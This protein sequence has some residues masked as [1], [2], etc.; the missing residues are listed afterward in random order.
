MSIIAAILLFIF[1]VFYIYKVYKKHGISFL[2]NPYSICIVL[3]ST[4]LCLYDFKFSSLYNPSLIINGLVLFIITVFLILYRFNHIEET[5]FIKLTENLKTTKIYNR[6]NL[7]SDVIFIAASIVF[8]YNISKY[9]LAILGSNKIN[10]QE[11]THYS[12]YFINL[13]VI[14]AQIKY[15]NFRK[16]KRCHD[17]I[18]L[19][20]SVMI[21]FLTLNRMPI[22]FIFATIYIYEIINYLKIK[23]K[24]DRTKRNK[25]IL[26][27]VIAIIVFVLA[28]GYVGNMRMDYVLKNIYHTTLQEHYGMSSYVPVSLVWVYIYLTSPLE[29][30]SFSLV[31]QHIQYT[32]FNNLF[33]PF[34]KFFANIFNQG[35]NYKAWVMSRV[36]YT[37]HL[38]E[39]VGLNVS[40]FITEGGFQDLGFIGFVIYIAIYSV[41][42]E[43]IIKLIKQ[44]R[45]ISSL[46]VYII[47]SN[48]LNL[49]IMS[50]YVNSLGIS[51]LIINII[52]V[53]VIELDYRKNYSSNL[54]NFVTKKVNSWKKR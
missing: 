27:T 18:I 48:I 6:Y 5:E 34:I 35:D 19:I 52:L 44:K 11:L 49:L 29:N 13:L 1:V 2:L 14:C 16:L 53:L 3:W 45:I 37:P 17:L 41:L 26:T 40:S 38:W 46:G 22:F 24:I 31:H 8:L 21:L 4:T 42:I 33:Y 25:F 51:L 28:F 15:I 43:W 50:V 23:E 9:G 20:L 30:A 39:K 32:Y 10:K 36:G 47:Y 54:Y 7:I 12:K